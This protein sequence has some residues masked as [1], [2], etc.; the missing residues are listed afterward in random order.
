MRSIHRFWVCA[1]LGIAALAGSAAAVWAAPTVAG[2]RPADLT[3]SGFSVVWQSS[4]PGL[5]RI[6]VFTDAAGTAEVT[7]DLEVV[8]FPLRGGDPAAAGAYEQRGARAALRA[9]AATLGQ[10]KVA[11]RGCAPAATYHYRVFT[12]NAAG[13]ETVWPASGTAPVTT[14]AE[15][16]FVAEAR[17][18]LVTLPA[19]A[20]PGARTGRLVLASSPEAGAPVS[21]FVGDG[22]G[23]DQAYLSLHQL[24]GA[25]GRNWTS[26]GARV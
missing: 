8:A 3:P 4:E 25:D 21:A 16:S 24:M 26:R 9:A 23:A 13:E 1:G 12:R 2:V 14:T 17:Q 10:M 11:V 18:L 15:N 19:A 7:T 20:V 5:P 6:A 22:A